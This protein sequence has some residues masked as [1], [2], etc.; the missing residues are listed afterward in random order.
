MT[1]TPAFPL[2]MQL[3]ENE[4]DNLR[5]KLVYKIRFHVGSVCPDVDDL[6]QE[7][8]ARFVRSVNEGLIREPEK[9]G[10]FLNSVCNNVIHEYRRRMWRETPYDSEVHPEPSVSPTAELLEL[11]DAIEAGLKEL[12]TRDQK[13]L[14][15]FLLEER[16]KEQICRE[17]GLSD[18]QF[19][20]I[21]FRA[22]GRFRQI[23]R[24]TRKQKIAARH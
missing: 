8:L 24:N 22:K 1:R 9:S 2:R 7:T 11:R 20:L 18:A 13:I 23:Y 17:T 16:S 6:A 15:E 5:R 14:R 12:S 19:R 3:N 10:A 4:I 21:L